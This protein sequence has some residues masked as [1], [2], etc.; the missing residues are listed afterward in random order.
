VVVKQWNVKDE[1]FFRDDELDPDQVERLI[2]GVKRMDF[3]SGLGL[4]P[5]KLKRSGIIYLVL[6]K[7][8]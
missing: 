1:T 6:L 5:I 4:F 2:L 3:D 7:M 8:I